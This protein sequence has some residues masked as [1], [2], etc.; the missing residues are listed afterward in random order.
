MHSTNYS[1]AIDMWAVGAIMAELYTLRPLFPGSSETDEIFKICSVIGTPT[2]QTWPEG[3][4]L[5][6]AMN[7]RFPTVAKTPLNTLIP[8]ASPEAID[9]MTELMLYDPT[10]RPSALKAM[11]HP[12]F[13]NGMTIPASI[14]DHKVDK[15][16]KTPKE[17]IA[18]QPQPHNFLNQESKKTVMQ[19]SVLKLTTKQTNE[20]DGTIVEGKR[21]NVASTSQAPTNRSNGPPTKPINNKPNLITHYGN[22]TNQSNEKPIPSLYGAATTVNQGL[23]QYRKSNQNVGYKLY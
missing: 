21:L 15:D 11:S 3:I 4:K 10:K 2:Q 20:I 12:Y 7:F 13:Q 19:Q 6:N 8:H 16:S 5:A 14:E 18:K 9:L 22:P 23:Y 17:D 1:A